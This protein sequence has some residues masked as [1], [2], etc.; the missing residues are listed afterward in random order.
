MDL[1]RDQLFGIMRGF[2]RTVDMRALVRWATL[3]VVF[4]AGGIAAADDGAAIKELAP[5]GKL[6]VAIAVG[7]ATSALYTVKGDTPGSY[8][9]VTITLATALAKKL[10]VPLEFVPYLGTGEIQ[11]SAAS[12]VW[13]VSFM[14]VDETRKKFVDFGAPYHLLQSTYLIAPGSDVKTVADANR[15]GVRIAGV[16]GTATFRA[17]NAA[18]AN[19]THITVNGVDEAVEL[20]KAGKA[21]AIALSRESLT[22]LKDKIPGSHILDG[23]FLNSTTA[24]AVPKNHPEALAYVT[25]FVE[26]A[27]ASGLVRKAFD[28]VGMKTS[29]MA[30]AGM[31]P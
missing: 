28:E 14:P 6:R 25:A 26:D 15:A 20:M 22:G 10:N 4:A 27:K 30:P 16:A 31:K 13:D 3:A 19:A 21:D 18:S 17:S 5:T 11:G 12:G 1:A 29:Q 24:V 8:H 7:P 9:G 2:G 23:G